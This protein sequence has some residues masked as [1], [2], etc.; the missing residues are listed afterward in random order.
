MQW[1]QSY[2]LPVCLK[3][4]QTVA[5][6]TT[7][8][9]KNLVSKCQYV[10]HRPYDAF[11]RNILCVLACMCTCVSIWLGFRD[12]YDVD[13]GDFTINTFFCWAPS[14]R[15]KCESF[16]CTCVAVEFSKN[17]YLAN[18]SILCVCTHAHVR[19][20]LGIVNA[21]QVNQHISMGNSAVVKF[22]HDVHNIRSSSESKHTCTR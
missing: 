15:R 10:I 6:C 21:E 5:K 3:E 1:R 22:E 8:V 19:V 7:L 14:V 2:C 16:K 20:F 13:S 9:E 11:E 4:L 17:N 18:A 12:N